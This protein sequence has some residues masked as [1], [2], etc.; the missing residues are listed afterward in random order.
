M[1][2]VSTFG[3]AADNTDDRYSL[4]G[5][6]GATKT[7]FFAKLISEMKR[8]DDDGGGSCSLF[9]IGDL[10][11]DDDDDDNVGVPVGVAEAEPFQVRQIWNMNPIKL[12]EGFGELLESTSDSTQH[13]SHFLLT[14]SLLYL[15]VTIFAVTWGDYIKLFLLFHAAT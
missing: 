11:L 7:R 12:L 1:V 5:T 8:P 15:V 6:I 9:A 13:S 10:D 14:F 3:P 2:S 4:F